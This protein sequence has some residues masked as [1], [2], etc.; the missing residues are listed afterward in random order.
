[1]ESQHR[2]RASADF[3]RARRRGRSWG[4]PY[5]SLTAVRNDLD[6]NRCG[7]VTSRRL[8]KAVVRNRVRRRLREI[9]RRQ[10]PNVEPGWDLVVSARPVAATATFLQLSDAVADVLRRAGVLTRAAM[11]P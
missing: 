9:V 3:E 2:L 11:A 10:M 5:L 7:F 4:T 1:M 6:S 8:G